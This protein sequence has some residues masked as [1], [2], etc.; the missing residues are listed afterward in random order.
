MNKHNYFVKFLI[1]INQFINSL[2]KRN[3]NKL[4][5]ANLKKILINNKVF[6]TIVLLVILFFSYLSLPNI[7]DKNQISVELKRELS[8]KLNLE[9]NFEKKL[10]YKFLPRPH[11]TTSASSLTFNE[12][13][14]SKID[15]LK[16]YVSLESLFS[17]KNMKIKNIIIEEANFNLNKNNYS[18]FIKLVD[19]NFADIKLE[20]L[21]SNIFYKNS[22]NDVLFINHIE[23][24]KYIYDPKELKNVLYSKNNIFNLPYSIELSNNEDERKLYSK[25][26]IGSLNLWL[27]NQFSYGVELKSGL[28]ELNFLNSKSVIEYKTDKNN[29]EFKLFDKAQKS[30]FSYNGKLNFRPFHSYLMGSATAVDFSHL[31]SDN[32]IIKQL[33]KTEILNNNNID[34]K[35]NISASKIKNFDSFTNIFFK[36]KIQEGLIDLDQTKFSW[37]NHANF[38]LT[39]SLIYIKNGKLVLDANTEIKL[40]NLNEIYKFLITPKNLRKKINKM[41]V[42]FTYLFDEKTL[43]INDIKVDG[44]AD[45][46]LLNNFNEINLKENSLQNKILFKNLLNKAIKSYAG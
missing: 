7:F 13:K 18:F 2:L 32:A 25:I 26:N 30:K 16:I 5:A 44:I 12:N 46:N 19:S 4:N 39:D 34:F 23:S 20:I 35:L 15:K 33:L 31:F 14:I 40:I 29:F 24:A 45:K 11:F 8:E 17:L 42:N 10:D 37:K 21:D 28:S 9:F 22:E 36:S 6:L 38:S 41:N 43:N 3:L 27:E 1:K